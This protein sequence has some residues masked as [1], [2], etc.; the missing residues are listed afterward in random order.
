MYTGDYKMNK[1]KL[2]EMIKQVITENRNNSV[3][4]EEPLNEATFA[5][6]KNKIN[7]LMI[8]FIAV[9][10]FRSERSYRKNMEIDRQIR[11]KILKPSGFS[12]TIV[13]GGFLEKPRDD[14]GEDI[15]DAPGQ[16]V[17]E[18]TYLVFDKETRP[19]GKITMDLFEL[20]KRISAASGQHSFAYGYPRTIQEPNQEET[21][22]EMFIAIY[23]PTA[24]GPGEKH[25]FKAPW[26]GPWSS[27][28]EMEHDDIFYTKV[29]GTRGKFAEEKLE[30]ANRMRPKSMIE[31]MKKQHQ[32]KYWKSLKERYEREK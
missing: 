31:A 17:N 14:K 21:S 27:Y 1:E 12:Y 29:R 6:A 30:E 7:N 20:G 24:P 26:A 28:E 15:E 18:K 3:L 9:S 8:P 23:E 19:G 22:K 10:A 16:E 25:R 4:L 11:E 32:I 5:S 13:E 2:K